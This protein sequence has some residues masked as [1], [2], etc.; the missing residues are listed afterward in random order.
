MQQKILIRKAISTDLSAII[1]MLADDAL[2]KT[3]EDCSLPLRQEYLQAF[4]AISRDQNQELLVMCMGEEIVGS[5]QLTFIPSLSFLGSLRAQI[6][7]VRIKSSCRDQGLGRVLLEDAIRR[8]KARGCHMV[9][10]TTHASRGR[11]KQ[12]YESMGFQASHV[13]MKLVWG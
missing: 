2:G 1:E 4:D 11:A 10:L 5:L 9:Q 8:A 6:E 13:G 3:R 7:G 12:F